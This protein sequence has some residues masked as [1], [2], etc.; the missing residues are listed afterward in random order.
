MNKFTKEL[1]GLNRYV[2]KKVRLLTLI[3]CLFNLTNIMAQKLEVSGKV[4]DSSTGES[5]PGVT[6]KVAGGTGGTVTDVDG[7][8]KITVPS[9]TA[10][11]EFSYVGYRV[12]KV[13]VQNR[14]ILD[15]EMLASAKSLNE[16]VVIGYGTVRKRD[17]TGAVTSVSDKQL[18]DIPVGSAAEAITGKLAGVQV[19]TTEG[20]PDAEIKIRVRGGGSI[21]QDNSP[22]YIVDGFPVSSISNIPPTDIQSIDVL[23]DGSST[24]IYGARGANGVIIVTTKSGIEGKTTVSLNSYVGVKKMAR[25]I[26][27]MNPYEYVMYQYELDQS[28]TF[29]SYYGDY[30]DLDIYKSMKGT[31][32]QKEIFGRT[33]LDQNYNLSVTGGTKATKYNL[34]LNRSDEKSIMINSGYERNNV[35]FKIN[36][37]LSK[38]LSLDFNNRL[39]YTVVDGAGVSQGS[40]ANTRLRNSVK[41]APTKG[42]R[43][44][45]SE[46]LNEDDVNS[47]E[48]ASLLYNPVKSANDEYKKQKQFSDNLNAAINWNIFTGLIFRSEW[49]YQFN[50]NRTD[51]VYGPATSQAKDNGGQPIANINNVEGSSWRNA[52]TL[53]FDKKNLFEGQNLT[54]LVGN[55]V[56]SSS[57]KSITNESRFFPATMGTNEVLALMNLGTPQNTVTNISPDENMESYFG[58]INYTV[59]DRYLLT[60]TYRADGSSKFKNHKW[61]YFPSA[62]LAWRMS[63]ENFLKNQSNWLSDLKLRVSYGSAGNNRIS[64]GL[65]EMT[66]SSS[67]DNNPYWLNEK[68]ASQLVPGSVLDNPELKWETTYTRNT[69]FDFSLFNSKISGTVDF[70]WNTTKDLLIQSPLPPFSG[71]SSQYQNIGQTS[72]KGMEYTLNAT[73]VDKKDF[74][75]SVSFNIAFNKNKVDK[76]VNGES[77]FKTYSSSWNGSAD[78]QD[79]YIVEQGKPLGQMYGYVTDGMYSFD[80]FTFNTSTNTWVIKPGVANSQVLTS[81]LIGPGMLKLKDLNGDSVI[82]ARDKTV[83]GNANPLHTGGFSINMTYKSFD[84]SAFFNW[85]YGNDIY[86]ANKIDNTAFGLTR[87]YQNLQNEMALGKRFT[88]IDPETGLNI[89]NGQYADPDR[90]KEL[91]KNATIWS[92]VMTRTPLHSWAIED[93]SFLRL[94]TL[95]FGYTLP[96]GISQ[97]LGLTNLRVYFTGYNLYCFTKYSGP[98]PEVDTRRS[99]PLTPGVDYSAYPRSRTFVGGFNLTF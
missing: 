13:E 16:V 50:R 62:A 91:N 57:S 89:Y 3:F 12:Q 69:G 44:F 85:S 11:L 51:N 81:S 88:I 23:K 79:D 97:R 15:V 76:F 67:N 87:K 41:Y 56:T 39:I 59:F 43:D 64:S 1:I 60:I 65:G 22:L 72:N 37:Q 99:T 35:S 95:T 82:D 75:L 84:L 10:S 21:T 17:L 28:S 25:A 8:Y 31:N 80:D 92:P 90:L 61:G 4:M 29:K 30:N 63:E 73:L 20:S 40:G 53:T 47:P 32:W 58:R 7:K 19:T 55:E 54:V 48:T 26:D 96:K 93:G 83:I 27:V 77:N 5:L 33:G 34:G 86:N 46:T 9:G 66:F 71:Y 6:V 36:T 78:P 49:G 70:Y 94:N 52:N 45:S 68:E 42:L 74:S 38:A 24:A 14:S 2:V 18:K 98:D